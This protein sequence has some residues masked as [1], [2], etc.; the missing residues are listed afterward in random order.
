MGVVQK[1]GLLCIWFGVL[2]FSF[3]KNSSHLIVLQSQYF[4]RSLRHDTGM[5]HIVRQ[6]VLFPVDISPCPVLPAIMSL[7]FTPCDRL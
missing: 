7:L 4:P 5:Y 2:N 1:L 3:S 6:A